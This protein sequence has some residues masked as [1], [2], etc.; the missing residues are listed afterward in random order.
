MSTTVLGNVPI[1]W[2]IAETGDYNGDGKSDILWIDNTGNVG[3]W[4]MNGSGRTS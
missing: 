1:N 2:T 4:F 3:V